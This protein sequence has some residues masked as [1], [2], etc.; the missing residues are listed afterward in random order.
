MYDLERD[1]EYLA[2]E[3]AIPKKATKHFTEKV[4]LLTSHLLADATSAL[5][6]ESK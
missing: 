3:L 2:L 4:H 1:Q 5:S 6:S